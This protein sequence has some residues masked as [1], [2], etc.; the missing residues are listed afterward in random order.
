MKYCRIG[1]CEVRTV[2]ARLPG[3]TGWGTACVCRAPA[4]QP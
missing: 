2:V 4:R 1:S 3:F